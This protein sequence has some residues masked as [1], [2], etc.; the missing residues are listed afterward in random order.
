M[1][2]YACVT[3]DAYDVIDDND[4][5]YCAHIALLVAAETRGKARADFT[6]WMTDTWNSEWDEY[7]FVLPAHITVFRKN[8]ERERG[9]IDYADAIYGDFWT[10]EDI[11]P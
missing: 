9:P 6:A 2:I 11:Q 10:P 7:G 3:E 5:E 4:G 8:V 1:N